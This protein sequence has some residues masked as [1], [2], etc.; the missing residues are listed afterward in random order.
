MEKVKFSTCLGKSKWP[1]CTCPKKV[2]HVQKKLNSLAITFLCLD[3]S[4]KPVINS[5]VKS[6]DPDQ[7]ASEEAS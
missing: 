2:F 5:L 3:N 7:L 1:Q 6:V 4:M